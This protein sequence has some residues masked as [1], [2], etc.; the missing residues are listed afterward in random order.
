MRSFLVGA[1]ALLALLAA[2]TPSGAADSGCRLVVGP[3]TLYAGM[4]F[5]ESRVECTSPQNRIRISTSLTR[6]GVVVS[7]A[8][9]DCR[10][11]SVCHLDV[12]A[13]ALD[14]EGDQVWCTHSSGWINGNTFVGS[15]VACESE[16][17]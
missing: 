6:D 2:S 11:V 1:A 9:R 5:P 17:F 15:A 14:A 12:D 3:P 4:V 10:K 16:P 7:S 13:H 8:R